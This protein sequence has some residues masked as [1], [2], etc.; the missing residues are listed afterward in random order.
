M[1]LLGVWCGSSN[2]EQERHGKRAVWLCVTTIGGV[3]CDVVDAP[4]SVR[5]DLFFSLNSKIESVQL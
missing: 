4:M 3:V 2:R 1:D 5:V